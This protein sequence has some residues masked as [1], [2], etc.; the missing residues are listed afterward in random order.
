MFEPAGTEYVDVNGEHK[1]TNGDRFATAI[2]A[3]E[4]CELN[5]AVIFDNE[6]TPQMILAAVNAAKIVQPVITDDTATSPDDA[7]P[8]DEK[9]ADDKAAEAE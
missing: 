7:A 3:I 2:E 6:K 5:Q 4:P 9:T 8:D 1:V